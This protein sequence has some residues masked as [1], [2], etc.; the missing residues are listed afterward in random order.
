MSDWWSGPK[1]PPGAI[2]FRNKFD[3]ARD[4]L[5]A[6]NAIGA[7]DAKFVSDAI[8]AAGGGG[9]G[10]AP[11]G[12]QYVTA[13][14]DATLT[15]E[16]VLT[17]TATV[18]WDFTTAGQAKANAVTGGGGNVSNSGTPTV[19]QYAKWVTATTIQGV[20]PAT[21]L[22]DIGA[23][24]AGSYQPL[25][26]DLTAIAALTGTNT[27]YYRSAAD[28]WSPV[29]IGTG[30]TFSGGTLAASGGGGTATPVPPQGR[31]TLQTATPVMTTTVLSAIAILYVP[32]VGDLVPI[33][34]GTKFVLL[35]LPGVPGSLSTAITDT[36]KNPSAIGA[37]KVNDW[38]IWNDAGTLR[39][40]HGPDWTNDTTRS[41]GT[42][43][44][45]QNGL[46]LNNVAITNACGA[47]RG[48]W[49]GTTRS[50]TNSGIDWIFG[51]LAFGGT[52]GF[53]GVANAY[54]REWFSTRVADN[55][56]SWTYGT[57][58][59]HASNTSNAM[60]VSV[61]DP[62]G[63]QTV[64][65]RHTGT[66]TNTSSL[67]SSV[68]IGVDSVTAFSGFPATGCFNT[69]SWASMV[70]LYDGVPGLGF[71]FLQAIENAPAASAS[72]FRGDNGVTYVQTGLTVLFQA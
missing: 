49:V 65:A 52:A 28:T 43:L 31:L 19:G 70:A 57:A 58:A 69:G 44:V 13:A 2:P 72:V 50:N 46:W 12:A 21:V 11:L 20:A 26:A 36:T 30:L 27:I 8:A 34:D 37:S 62:W 33:Y 55:T 45:Q 53:F 41:A 25:D 40:S 54:N 22:S 4:P 3:S 39:L 51:G 67:F 9:G 35:A 38:F 47:Q 5:T 23:Q 59:W 63:T 61:V 32:Y 10:G 48:T 6:R 16:R 29:T 71:H 1:Q 60:R 15:A 14:A 18:T 17:N 56:D 24:P 66:A 7:V 42:A 68:G 64:S